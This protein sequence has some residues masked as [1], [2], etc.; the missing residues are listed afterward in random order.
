VTG[1]L[2]DPLRHR[3]GQLAVLYDPVPGPLTAISIAIRAGSRADGRLPGL[4]HMAEHMLFQGTRGLDQLTINRRAGELG[5]EHDADTGHEDMMVHFE[6]FNEDVEEALALLAEQLFHSTVPDD[7]FAKERRVVIDEI[8]GRQEDPGN[9]LHER[10]WER[11]FAE[12]LA[13]PIAGSIRSVRAITPAAVRRF[14]ARHFVP[15]NM[16]LAVVGG[17]TPGA[18]RRAVTRTFPSRGAPAPSPPPRP[19]RRTRGYVRLRRQDLAQAYL[20]R[21]TAAPTE[22]RP[23][24]ALSLAIEIVGADPDARLFQEIRER[25]GLGYDVGAGL[26]HGREWAVAVISASAAREHETRLCDTVARTC[27]HAATGFSADELDRARKKVRYRFARLADSRMDRAISHA[28]R[29]ANGHPTLASTARL[30]E[31]IGLGEV[32]GAWRALLRAPTLTAV[33]SA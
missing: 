29:E 6:V 32:D 20:V 33:L 1:R 8:R 16:V 28:A 26:E 4:A 18:L 3:H 2:R 30:V 23:T 14:I 12:P 31:R 22:P 25:L 11:F 21:L 19:R 13:H 7:R 5:G 9:L 15:A 17:I 10:A 24:L 27:E